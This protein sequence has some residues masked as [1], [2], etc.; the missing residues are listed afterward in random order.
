MDRLQTALELPQHLRVRLT[1][2]TQAV[3]TEAALTMR[4]TLN[5]A[6]PYYEDV[7]VLL[8]PPGVG[9]TT[10][11]FK[12]VLDVLKAHKLVPGD[13]ELEGFAIISPVLSTT[14]LAYVVELPA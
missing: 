11:A 6:G 2:K 9:H 1:Y 13:A 5:M 4:D 7:S 10:E 14:V 8:P 12:P 3:T